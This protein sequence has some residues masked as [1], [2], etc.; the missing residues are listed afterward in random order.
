MY[1]KEGFVIVS[2][3]SDLLSFLAS[4]P[5]VISGD[6]SFSDRCLFLQTVRGFTTTGSSILTDVEALSS[7][8]V[9]WRSFYPFSW[10]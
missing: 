2:L 8:Y 3:S 9:I 4:L 6:I 10:R 7:L 1:A 5:F